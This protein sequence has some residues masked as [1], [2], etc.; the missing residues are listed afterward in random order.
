MICGCCECY[1]SRGGHEGYCIH[2]GAV[3]AE[4]HE[5]TD[6]KYLEGD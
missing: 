2:S 3:V 6:C 5:E 1:Y 4:D